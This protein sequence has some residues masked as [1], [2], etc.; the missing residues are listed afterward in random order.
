MFDYKGMTEE[1]LKVLCDK[2][3]VNR[4]K[5]K[6]LHWP[7]E[8]Y[9]F[10]SLLRDFAFFP[11]K[12]SLNVYSEHGIGTPNIG[13][14][15]INNDAAFMF[16]FADD[17]LKNYK[18]KTNKPVYKI[19]SPFVWYKKKNKIKQSPDAKGTLVFPVH[20]IPEEDTL[21]D[22]DKYI[23][24]LKS[25]PEKMHPI[26]ACFHMH[27]INKEEKIYKKFM[28]AGISVYTAGN[29]FDVR[30]AQRFYDILKNFKYTSSNTIGSYAFYSVDFGIPFFIYGNEPSYKNVSNPYHGNENAGVGKI[31]N[32]SSYEEIYNRQQKFVISPFDEEI[33]ITKEQKTLADYCL[34]INNHISRFKMCFLLYWAFLKYTFTKVKML[35]KKTK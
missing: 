21:L 15:E 16:V 19:L 4:G 24:Q 23:E 9:S 32:V 1:E 12:L 18:E 31:Y 27:D 34:G 22:W 29:V 10:G 2:K 26:C 8:V 30:F 20:S 7:S 13:L 33:T 17:K 3:S 28:D 25:L 14:N 5:A 6:W 11:K 35:W